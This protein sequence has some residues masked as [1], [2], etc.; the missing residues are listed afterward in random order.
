MW[1]STDEVKLDLTALIF[2]STQAAPSPIGCPN[3]ASLMAKRISPLNQPGQEA[4][5]LLSTITPS[6]RN[7]PTTK[8]LLSH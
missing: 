6:R 8:A 1:D 5:V 7:F 3:R 4:P 2:A